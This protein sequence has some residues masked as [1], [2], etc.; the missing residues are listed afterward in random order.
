MKEESFIIENKNYSE[1]VQ[2]V[3]GTVEHSSDRAVRNSFSL[4]SGEKD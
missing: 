3:F 2:R 1:P 4:V